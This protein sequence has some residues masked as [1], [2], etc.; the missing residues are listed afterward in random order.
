MAK[1]ETPDQKSASSQL[2]EAVDAVDSVEEVLNNTTAAG[3]PEYGL[4]I[5]DDRISLLLDCP[6]PHRDLE[7][8]VA[9]IE[10]DFVKMEL[11]EYPD[12]ETLSGIL[13][14]ACGAGEHLVGYPLVQGWLPTPPV[15]GK[16][17]WTREFFSEG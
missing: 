11:P 12:P 15:S 10:E 6:D 17:E 7:T 1:T 3:E 9:R 16:L 5:S 13:K 4:R 14:K 8:T 2:E